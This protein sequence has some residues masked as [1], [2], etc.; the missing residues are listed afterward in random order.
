METP[1][2]VAVVGL[3]MMGQMHLGCYAQ[4]PGAKIVAVCD[5][6]PDKLSG[7]SK[8]AGNIANDRALDMSGVLKTS[9][10][11]TLL[12]DPAVDLLDFCLPTRSHARAT[13][14]ALEAG[15]HVLCEKPMA[16]TT[17]ECD[18]VI[19]AQKRSGKFVLIGHSTLR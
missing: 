7:E 9:E 8:V 1:I 12:A 14:A 3:G 13:V 4:N 18:A 16:W 6:D 10:I 19:D 17:D 2:N 11:E 15:K 5:Q